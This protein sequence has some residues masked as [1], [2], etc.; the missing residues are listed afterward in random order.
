[1]TDD[2]LIITVDDVYS[3]PSFSGRAGFCGRGAR[4]WFA[5]HRLDWSAFVRD[6]ISAT[7]VLATGDAMGRRVV[8]HARA[9]RAG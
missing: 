9:R 6:G 5:H 4:A 7:K 8:E 3:V 2:D 1:M